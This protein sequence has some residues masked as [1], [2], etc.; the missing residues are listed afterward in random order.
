[1]AKWHRTSAHSLRV[2]D[3]VKL[4]LQVPPDWQAAVTDPP[5]VQVAEQ[6]EP[7][8]VPLQLDGQVP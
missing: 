7:M 5:K 6:L 4:L 3:P 2:Q 8:A 1:M